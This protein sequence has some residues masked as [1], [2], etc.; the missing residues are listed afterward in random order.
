MKAKEDIFITGSNGYL[1]KHLVKKL[2]DYDVNIIKNTDDLTLG[3]PEILNCD[4]IIHLANCTKAGTYCL[5]HKADQWLDHQLMH[6]NMLNYWLNYNKKAKFVAFG[7]S[8][9]YDPAL[10]N[11]IEDMYLLGQPDKDLYVYAMTKRML[12]IGLQAL[13]HQH[14]MNYLYFVP[15]TLYGPNFSEDDSHFI[16]DVIKKIINAKQTGD[17]VVLWGDG[18]Q[19]RELVYID[20]AVDLIVSNIFTKSNEV[21][22]ICSGKEYTIREYAK[23]ICRIIDY[24]FEKII[25]DTSKFMGVRSKVLN[26]TK[27]LDFNFTPIEQGIKNTIQYLNYC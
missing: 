7:T 10:Y 24:D 5:T 16:F 8:C 15:S 4:I 27:N 17:K 23:I 14:N 6:T 26:N 3:Q 11:K 12:L 21:I 19:K 2:S 13:N 1:G 22:N 18:Y 25:F 20:D 9:A